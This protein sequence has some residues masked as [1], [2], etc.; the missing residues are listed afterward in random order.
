[1]DLQENQ[2]YAQACDTYSLGIIAYQL[3]IGDLPFKIQSIN[4][5]DK[6]IIWVLFDREEC[7]NMNPFVL[8]FLKRL[9]DSNP[10]TRMTP[11]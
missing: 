9:L 7:K 3:I 10:K 5:F 1:M 11:K 4:F 6:K 8:E 2:K